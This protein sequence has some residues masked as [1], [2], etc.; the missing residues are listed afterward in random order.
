MVQVHHY[1]RC[2]VHHYYHSCKVQRTESLSSDLREECYAGNEYHLCMPDDLGHCRRL[3]RTLP[4]QAN[5]WIVG[6]CT[7]IKMPQF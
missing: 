7:T 5:R 2:P 1:I 6:P 4:V 3:L